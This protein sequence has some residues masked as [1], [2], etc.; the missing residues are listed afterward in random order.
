VIENAA[1]NTTSIFYDS[2]VTVAGGQVLEAN[3]VGVA[4]A[5][6]HLV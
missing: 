4:P 2:N 3:I 5:V 6:I 1:T